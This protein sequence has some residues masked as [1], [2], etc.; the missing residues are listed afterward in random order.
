MYC[1]RKLTLLIE[2]NPMDCCSSSDVETTFDYAPEIDLYT[3]Q[4]ATLLAQTPEYQE[5]A[6]QS[7]AIELDAEV[8]RVS[9]EIRNR[10]M[11]YAEGMGKTIEAL[12]VELESLPAVRAYRT[13]ETA[14]KDL[15]HSVDQVISG[16]AG[17]QFGANAQPKAC[18]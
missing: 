11:V 8:K 3:D 17:V 9:K 1:V 10:Q 4:L 12:Q 14:V 13:A 18:G 16:A 15:F 2:E 6:R 5:F 7:Q